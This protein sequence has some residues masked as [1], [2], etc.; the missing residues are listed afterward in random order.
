MKVYRVF[1][2]LVFV[3][4][5]FTKPVNNK[6]KAYGHKINKLINRGTKILRFVCQKLEKRG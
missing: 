5:P 3:V 6:K 1:P 2:F 4:C